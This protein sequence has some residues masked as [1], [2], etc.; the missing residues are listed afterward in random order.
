VRKLTCKEPSKIITG[1]IVRKSDD[2]CK[3]NHAR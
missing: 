1:T 3:K 2:G